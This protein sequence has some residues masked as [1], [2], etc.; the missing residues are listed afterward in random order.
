LI[1]ETTGGAHPAEF[2][3]IDDQFS[4]VAA[5]EGAGVEPDVTVAG[6]EALDVAT[7]LAAKEISKNRS[8]LSPT[9][10]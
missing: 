5:W 10:P 4:V 2:K 8:N 9:K 3:R 1:G 7:K 6:A